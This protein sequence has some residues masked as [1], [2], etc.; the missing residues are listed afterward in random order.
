MRDVL[1]VKGVQ[2]IFA[3]VGR[4][5]WNLWRMKQSGLWPMRKRLLREGFSKMG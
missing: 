4:R 2:P 5:Q 3:S 1:G